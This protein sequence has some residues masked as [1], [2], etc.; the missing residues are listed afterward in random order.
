MDVYRWNPVSR[1]GRFGGSFRLEID[2]NHRRL[3]VW[4]SPSSWHPI[5]QAGAPFHERRWRFGDWYDGIV[6]LKAD[7]HHYRKTDQQ[8]DFIIALTSTSW[9]SRGVVKTILISKGGMGL[10]SCEGI[11]M[12]PPLYL[13]KSAIRTAIIHWSMV[14]PNYQA[15]IK[16][17]PPK[18]L[19]ASLDPVS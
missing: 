7:L 5:E 8:F 16:K 4:M 11:S 19:M 13:T 3:V 10:K 15:V 18:L 1:D 17:I 12:W 9:G 2:A 6:L 14:K